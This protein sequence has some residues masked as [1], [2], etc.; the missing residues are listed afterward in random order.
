MRPPLVLTIADSETHGAAGIQADLKTFT[1]L[2][3]YGASAVSMITV[4]TTNGVQSTHP[5]PGDVVR[6]QIDAVA[7]D[8]R[9]DATKIGA[10]GS[11]A[12]VQAVAA[13]LRAHRGRLGR[14]VLD[15]VMVSADGTALISAEG[16]SA[17]ATELLPLADV[18]TPNMAEAAQLLGRPLATS[19][20]EIREQALA[21]QA[22]GPGA[23]L[24]TGGRLEGEDVVDVL[25]H[26]GG[27]DLLRARRLPDRRV[28]GAGSTLSAA[29]AAQLARIAEFDRAG[30]LGEIGEAGTD[31]DMVTIVASAREFVASATE[32]AQGWQISRHEGG[33]SPV[34]H[35]ITL[36]RD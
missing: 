2:G 34:N 9:L 35:L 13:A 19:I 4:V 23:V 30:E 27:T 10:L 12:A 8:L 18:L 20:D 15:P 32:N 6:R 29:I 31:D 14:I 36:D 21:L 24:I 25:V 33:F 28:R 5:L 3:T 7:G 22:L 11:A 1:A 17:L 16:A 26:Q